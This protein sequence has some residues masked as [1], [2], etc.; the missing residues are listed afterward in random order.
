MWSEISG[1]SEYYYGEGHGGTVDAADNEALMQLIGKIDRISSLKE[2]SASYERP[3][4][5]NT[6]RMILRTSPE[7]H[8][9]RYV[10]TDE[11]D[12]IFDSRRRKIAAMVDE[13]GKQEGKQ[14]IDN[15]LRFYWWAYMLNR[16][17][18]APETET[19]TDEQGRNRNLE[20]WIPGQMNA[21]LDSVRI[22]ATSKDADNTLHLSFTYRGRPITSIDYT[23]FDGNEWSA[24]VSAK[25]GTG[26]V[27]MR[28]ETDS[29]DVRIEYLYAGNSRLDV[30]VERLADVVPSI[31]LD[32]ASK[33]FSGT[34]DKTA[35]NDVAEVL[36]AAEPE[37][38]RLKEV[39]NT[40]MYNEILVNVMYAVKSRAYDSVSRYFTPEG[41]EIWQRI[42][43]YGNARILDTDV[44]YHLL[45]DN[46]VA[47]GIKMAF[48]FRNG[49]RRMFVEDVVFTFN[50]AG[51]IDNISFGMGEQ[52]EKDILYKGAWPEEVRALIM[53]FLENYKTAF[54]LKRLDYIQ[55]IFDD[56][57]VIVV[58]RKINRKVSQMSDDMLGNLSMDQIEYVRRTKGE[59]MESLERCFASN[60]F[61]NLRF[62]NTDIM[63]C[64]V[65]GELYGMQ[66]RQDYYST[67]YGDTGYLTLLVDFNDP[68]AP[69][70]KVRT[71]QPEPDPDFG[72]IT[73]YDF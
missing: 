73:P 39:E 72:L 9:V 18:P 65:G 34:P 8:V 19:Y 61:I 48:S 42:V 3:A 16:S 71:W 44:S 32:K 56:N 35:G 31:S 10:K 70:I 64:V 15:A 47:R 4:K 63:K 13:A 27:E 5:V 69:L 29:V 1:S 14:N 49:V 26:I 25:D 50:Q 60:E 24:I 28:R 11:V 68:N 55:G 43:K 30:D 52:G 66:I 53:E 22:A 62:T 6:Q 20:T 67:N 38:T 45:R 7:V 46:V 23:Y 21:I 40:S 17:M 41:H 33:K 36:P 51:L 58:G 57:A 37:R 59:Y 54:A 2:F 12:A